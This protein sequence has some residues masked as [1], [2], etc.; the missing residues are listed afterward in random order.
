MEIAILSGPL[1]RRNH[2]KQPICRS[3][4]YQSKKSRGLHTGVFLA[5]VPN[6][7]NKLMVDIRVPFAIKSSNLQGFYPLTLWRHFSREPLSVRNDEPYSP[8]FMIGDL[9][10]PK[11]L[12]PLPADFENLKFA[13]FIELG[14]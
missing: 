12:D 2:I 14:K 9:N 5:L 11:K 8:T 7:E 3:I 13:I 10:L 4:R 1:I 6:W